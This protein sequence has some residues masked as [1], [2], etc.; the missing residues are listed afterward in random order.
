MPVTDNRSNFDSLKS[1]SIM[2]PV[3]DILTPSKIGNMSLKFDLFSSPSSL[4]IPSTILLIATTIVPVFTLE[5]VSLS[6]SGFILSKSGVISN[7]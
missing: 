4:C 7:A 5:A 1:I 2:L 3:N 6:T